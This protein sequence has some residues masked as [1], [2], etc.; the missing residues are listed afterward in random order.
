MKNN[1][2]RTVLSITSIVAAVC[3]PLLTARGRQAKHA[4]PIV[5]MMAPP[6]YPFLARRTHIEGVVRLKIATDGHRVTNAQAEGSA[7][8]PL[9]DLAEKNIRTWQFEP[10]EPTT[11]EVTYAYR[12]VTYS[13]F[14]G[15]STSVTLELPTDVKISATAVP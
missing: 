9:V 4:L 15:D 11:F 14:G 3:S 13:I 5:A 8:P 6:T 1:L 12:L 10:G 2:G 7:A